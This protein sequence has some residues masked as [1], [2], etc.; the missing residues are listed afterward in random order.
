MI[1]ISKRKLVSFRLDE[2]IRTKLK[3]FALKNKTSVQEILESYILQLL[4]QHKIE[5]NK[6]NGQ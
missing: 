1:T 6:N 3:I 5:E 4:E 2:D